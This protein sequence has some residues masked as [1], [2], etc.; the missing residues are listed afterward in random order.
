[1]DTQEGARISRTLKKA[2]LRR[3]ECMKSIRKIHSLAERCVENA[4]L[5]SQLSFMLEEVDAI[6]AAFVSESETVMDCL[7]D[8]DRESEYSVDQV[9][10]LRELVSF[11]R[12][13]LNRYSSDQNAETSIRSDVRRNSSTSLVGQQSVNELIVEG[14]DHELRSQNI[15]DSVIVCANPGENGTNIQVDSDGSSLRSNMSN[16]K[17]VRL[18]E[19]PLPTFHGDIFKWLTFRDR[20]ISMVDQRPNINDIDKFYYLTGCLKDNALEAIS[21]IPVSGE[22]YKLAWSTLTARFDRP[23]LVAS[24][25]ID[26]LLSAPKASTETLSDLHKFLLVFDEG[27]SVLDSMKL[28]DLGDFI[29]FSVASRC[30]PSYSIKLF[31]SQLSNGFPTVR[32][33]LA[34]VKSR[35][36]V[37]ECVPNVPRDSVHKSIKQSVP[38]NSYATPNRYNSGVNKFKKQQST[39]LMTNTV[40]SKSNVLCLICKGSHAVSVCHKFTGWSVDVREKWVRENR[41]CFRCLRVGHWA[42]ECKSPVQCTKCTRR[43]HPLLHTS[44]TGMNDRSS[45]PTC[46]SQ[47]SRE[48]STAQSSLLGSSTQNSSSVILGTAL[49]HIRD[50]GGVLHTMRALVDSASQISAITADGAAQ[51]GLRVTRWTAP[52]SGLSGASVLNV[53]GMVTCDI[54]PRFSNEPF[55]NFTAWVFPTVTG[56]MPSQSVS[57]QVAD[58]YKNLA[59]ADPS[60]T[61]PSKIDLLLG[62]DI[63]ARIL[64]GKRVSVGDSYPVAL[65]SIFGWIIIGPV[66]PSNNYVPTSHHISLVSSIESLMDKFWQVEEPEAA[67]VTFTCDG[68]CEELFRDKCSRDESGRFVVPLLFRQTVADNIFSGSRAVAV[69]RFESLERKFTSDDRLREAYCNFMAEYLSLGHMSPATTT[70][71][72]FIPHHAVF[73]SSNSEAKIRVVF[74]ASAQSFSS[75]SLNQ[76]LFAGP[77]LQQDV[78]DVLMR[79]RLPRYAF[80]ADINKM[81]RQVLL[82]PEHR[83]YQ[84]I[85]WRASPQDE[86]KAYELNTVTYGVNCAPFLAIRVLREIAESDC[87]DVPSVRDA[88]MFNTYVDDIC[89]GGDTVDEIITLQTDLINIL[90][91]AGMSLKKWS[92]NNTAVLDRVLPEDRAGGMSSFDDDTCSGSKVLGL[93]WSQRDD[94]FLYIVQPER[95]VSTKRGML[96]L[97]ARIFD[98]LG[99]LAPVIFFA[100]HLMQRV[101]QLGISWD[102]PLPPEIVDVWNK[103]VAD[104][105]V[106]Q[107]VTVPRFIGTQTGV[108]GVLCGFCDASEKGYSAVVYLRLFNQSG[109]PV[110]SLLGSKTKTAPLNSSTIPRLELCAAVLLARWMVRIKTALNNKIQIVN[111][112]AWSDST[113]VLSWLK[114]PHDKFKVFVSNRIHKVITLLPDCHWD[115]ISSRDNPADCASRGVFPT[116]LVH[117]KLYWHGPE[118]LYRDVLDGPTLSRDINIENLPEL[119]I[120][121]PATLVTKTS[122]T[123][124]PEWYSRFSSYSHMIRVVAYVYRFIKICKR[125]Q[126]YVTPFLT[127]AELDHAAVA[128][129]KCSQHITFGKLLYELSQNR[130]ITA[131]PIARLR[132]FIDSRGLICVGGRLSNADVPETQKHPILLGKSSHLSILVIRHWHEI[133]GHGGPRIVTSLIN[134]SF[135]I[136]SLNSLIRSVLCKCVTCV[137]L[138]AV[139]PQPIMSDLPTSR[140]SECHPFSCV[141]IDFA[142]PIVMTEH[143]LRKARQF[144]VYIAVFVCFAVKA[145]HLEYVSDLSTD[146]F[147][148]SLQRFVA[149]RGLPKDIYTDCGTNFI[150]ASNQLRELVNVSGCKDHLISRFQ[151]TWHFNPPGA[152]HFG[153]LWEAAVRSAKRLMTRIMG[154]HTFSVEELNTMLCR[155]EAILN[156]R[157]L[158]P[159]SSDPAEY[160]CL[161]PGHFLIGRPLLSLP[162]VYIADTAIPLAQR[163]KLIN[164]CAQYFWR[165]WR[166][167]YLNTLQMRNR[168]M[169]DVPNISVNDM[170]IIKEPNVPPLQWR[171]ARVQEVFP[172]ADGVVRVIRVRTATGTFTRPVVKVVKLPSS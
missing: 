162:E 18:P 166:N 100:K 133:T 62:A 148:A 151:C 91:R 3:N 34:F 57:S 58:K 77:K 19:I 90:Q 54:Q 107:Q 140:V 30:L 149:R 161:T 35:I 155:I 12:A 111:L 150:G 51:L 156:S 128:I 48:E 126:T 157:P 158:V 60:F 153:G 85:L 132:P 108:Q 99:L 73:K 106:L 50:C 116:D 53:K 169:T 22:N 115:Y 86:L 79:F 6:W 44:A 110:I 96:S 8:L 24:S 45:N 40:I 97:I 88:L 21:G 125:R 101:W 82:I 33:L 42:P 122:D 31:E 39:S 89:V 109:P 67:P 15:H 138:A 117:H 37:L 65:G 147:L 172:G 38:Q 72:Y 17:L 118:I 127:R 1:M 113:T 142:G 36:N 134:Q 105:P 159:L 47:V 49:V 121:S 136:L 11:A 131:G 103:F 32:D 83:R 16:V 163:W 124:E 25:L 144:K 104:L 120:V 93:Q 70:G 170:V 81:Y 160:D 13:T 92:S 137:R 56:N 135:W 95:L 61:I 141:G 28:P 2:S 114:V 129:A 71:S 5:V 168:W 9:V 119:K 152:P 102:D 146:A 4:S 80:T 87:V 69:K 74:D 14:A 59:L 75:T 143:R 20:F 63:F 139:N 66:P 41:C 55:I 98:P 76:C 29:L 26:K 154:E 171:M 167:E 112:Y 46:N 64:N 7:I 23:R 123:L 43:H 68:K 78:I 27:V 145:V 94:T 165:R 10:E 84:H 130:P 52:V 164:Q